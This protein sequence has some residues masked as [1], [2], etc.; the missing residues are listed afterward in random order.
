MS[1]TIMIQDDKVT[2]VKRETTK[3]V[4]LD[5]FISKLAEKSPIYIPAL[6][7][8]CRG[9]ISDS[10]NTLFVIEQ[11]PMT[12]KL[13]YGELSFN[14]HFPWTYYGVCIQ[15]SPVVCQHVSVFSAKDRI[16]EEKSLV[17][18]IPTSNITYGGT[19]GVIP[20]M[21]LGGVLLDDGLLFDQCINDLVDK[22]I[23]SNYNGDYTDQGHIHRP[24]ILT[25]AVATYSKKSLL[26]KD[27]SEKAMRARENNDILYFYCW[28]KLS[29]AM[30]LKDFMK[31]LQLKTPIQYKT[32]INGIFK[33]TGGEI[34]F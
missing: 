30:K 32:M 5:D 14:L 24:K 21:C 16:K 4:S 20:T 9:F 7:N 31:N 2:L 22:I 10:L 27:T 15:N 19:K 17:G 28:E 6:P 34:D 3:E 23:N 1:D 12:R 29:K 26:D 33:K 11:M 8:A 13:S 18:I 25:D